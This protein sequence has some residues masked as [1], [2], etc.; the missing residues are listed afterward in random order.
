[1]TVASYL[2]VFRLI[3]AAQLPPPD[4]KNAL[5]SRQLTKFAPPPHIILPK[6]GIRLLP[7]DAFL[8]T[9]SPDF[10]PFCIKVP[11][12]LPKSPPRLVNGLKIAQVPLQQQCLPS[13]QIIQE[14]APSHHA[15]QLPVIADALV[16]RSEERRVGKECISRWSP[17][18]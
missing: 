12:P 6:Y 5:T 16:K 14:P 9:I 2:D 1:M 3:L 15:P 17:Y 4:I 13:R 8:N 18:H 10:C 7:Y 11:P